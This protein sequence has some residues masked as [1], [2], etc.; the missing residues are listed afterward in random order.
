[1]KKTIRFFCIGL[2]PCFMVLSLVIPVRAEDNELSEPHVM[3]IDDQFEIAG[4]LVDYK[5]D[6]FRIKVETTSLT[7]ATQ[8]VVIV[9]KPSGKTTI[10]GIVQQTIAQPLHLQT[11]SFHGPF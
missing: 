11:Q 3:S 7:E 10:N 1:M 8:D 2:L 4:Y 6:E 9:D 5:E